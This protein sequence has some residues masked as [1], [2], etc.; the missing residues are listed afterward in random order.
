MVS[1]SLATSKRRLFTHAH[2]FGRSIRY[3]GYC[4]AIAAK[5]A[6]GAPD[7]KREVFAAARCPAHVLSQNR[8]PLL[9]RYENE[10]Y[11][12]R[13]AVRNDRISMRWLDGVRPVG[14]CAEHRH[15]VPLSGHRG[16]HHSVLTHA[17]GHSVAD[18]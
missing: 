16:D 5:S 17:A 10:P 14:N 6:T 13:A 4:D 18:L 11:P 3:T 8:G 2:K 12:L 1:K 9:R 7:R 15:D